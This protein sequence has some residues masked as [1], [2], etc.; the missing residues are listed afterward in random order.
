MIRRGGCRC[1]ALRFEAEGEPVNVRF[2]HC[3][4]CQKTTG[5]PFFSRA[6]YGRERL[7]ITGPLAEH[8]SS[9]GSHRGFCPTCGTVVF[10]L[11]QDVPFAGVALGAFDEPQGLAPT[12]HIFTESKLSWLKLDDGLPQYPQGAP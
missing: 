11:R 4:L 1:G 7:T 5:Q 3:R 6:L 10:A 12:A 9:A 2:C 8:A